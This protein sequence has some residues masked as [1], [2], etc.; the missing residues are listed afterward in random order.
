[1][2][3]LEVFRGNARDRG[4][5]SRDRNLNLG[6]VL[7]NVRRERAVARKPANIC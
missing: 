7:S 5:T 2:S 3:E 4:M 1:M 6:K